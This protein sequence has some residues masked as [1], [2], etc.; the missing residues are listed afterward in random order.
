MSIDIEENTSLK[1]LIGQ[2]KYIFLALLLYSFLL[3]FFCTKLSPLYECN[4][5]ADLHIYFNIGKGLMN[6]LVPYKDLFDHKGP[7]IFFIYGLGY[8]ISPDT[9][10]GIYIIESILFFVGLS[11]VYIISRYFLSKAYAF[12][13]AILF[14]CTYLVFSGLGGAAEDF[15]LIFEVISLM[16]FI[17]YFKKD[18]SAKH[19]YINLFLQGILLALVFFIKLNFIIFQAILVLTILTN[20]LSERKFSILIKSTLAFNGGFAGV[21]AIISLYFIINSAFSDFTFAYITFNSL[22]A[23]AGE[24]QILLLLKQ[25]TIKAIRFLT[26]HP[27]FCTSIVLGV[28]FFTLTRHFLDNIIARIGVL[29]SFFATLFI[30]LMPNVVMDYYYIILSIFSIYTF[31]VLFSF[32]AKYRKLPSQIAGICLLCFFG[33]FLGNYQKQFFGESIKNLVQ[34]TEAN[35]IEN[36]FG[37]IIEKEENPTLLCLGLNRGLVLF[38]KANIKPSVK[39]FFTPNIFHDQAPQI[40]NAQDGYIR[41]RQIQFIIITKDF[42]DYNHFMEPTHFSQNYN[43]IAEFKEDGTV[44]Y[45]Y[46]RIDY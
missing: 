30:V 29:V 35:S 17:L 26:L 44:Y 24:I 12:A 5:W 46:K 28:G 32:I 31:I 14:S 23:N 41:N 22:Y 13:V 43:K 7:L 11:A 9:F 4:Y 34:R 2:E 33:L 40:R 6:G 45:L 1:K 25:I 36:Y 8:L 42:R 16:L 27:V 10:A 3:F 39:Y 19:I 37:N 18:L 38:T 15:V 20:F 21:T